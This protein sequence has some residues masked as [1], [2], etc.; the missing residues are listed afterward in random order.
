MRAS[1]LSKQLCHHKGQYVSKIIPTDLEKEI[2]FDNPVPFK[3]SFVRTDNSK[4]NNIPNFNMTE[5][6]HTIFTFRDLG[7][8]RGD[9]IL[10]DN[11]TFIIQDLNISY[12]QSTTFKSIKQYYISI[13]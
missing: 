9:K 4:S 6:S 5:T 1:M 3:F 2:R 8:K 7:F 11:L 13:K 12:Y 10:F